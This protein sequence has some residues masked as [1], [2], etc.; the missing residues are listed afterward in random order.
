[1]PNLWYCNL[2]ESG[3][4]M[5]A[6]REKCASLASRNIFY[7]ARG[8]IVVIPHPVD[9]RYIDY[10]LGLQKIPNESVRVWT[11]LE[12]QSGDDLRGYHFRPFIQSRPAYAEAKKA[13]VRIFETSGDIVNGGLI[14]RLNDKIHFKI[15]SGYLGIKTPPGATAHNMQSL[16]EHI[17]Q[18]SSRDHNHIFLRTPDG[19][20]GLGNLY[21]KAPAVLSQLSQWYGG[22][23]ILVEFQLDLQTTPGSLFYVGE[24]TVEFLGV[25]EQIFDHGK[26]VGFSY[27]HSDAAVTAQIRELSLVYAHHF[28]KL[29]ARGMANIDWG[30]LNRDHPEVG[31]KK[32]E[33]V[34]FECNFR[35]NALNHMLMFAKRLFGSDFEKTRI[36]GMEGVYLQNPN[37]TFEEL[38]EKIPGFPHMVITNPPK[39]G[40]FGLALFY[41]DERELQ[42]IKKQITPLTWKSDIGLVSII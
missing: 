21:G 10:V 2:E 35:M 37:T 13:G 8:D 19:V 16:K 20:G 22:G 23:E 7:A 29:G 27:P 15:I 30:V 6:I 38:L 33:I 26:Y 32:G 18:I 42:D 39:E 1:M 41:Q 5:P 14:E 40:K 28:Q 17:L 25:D 36:I 9:P 11:N 4:R 34:A 3:A 12:N 31:M 24:E